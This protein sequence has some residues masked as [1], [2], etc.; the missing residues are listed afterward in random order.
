MPRW[1]CRRT[2]WYNNNSYVGWLFSNDVSRS[3]QRIREEKE[4]S[5]SEKA[6]TSR[7]RARSKDLQVWLIDWHNIRYVLRL[8]SRRKTSFR[9]LGPNAFCLRSRNQRTSSSTLSRNS[10]YIHALHDLC[11]SGKVSALF[12]R[13]STGAKDFLNWSF[14]TA[15]YDGR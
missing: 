11:L 3:I 1:P 12:V 15:D 2:I 10:S 14:V 7:S 9:I 4:K 5:S 6:A 13:L 8:Q